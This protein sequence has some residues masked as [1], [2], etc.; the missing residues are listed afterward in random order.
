MSTGPDHYRKSERFLDY[1][2]QAYNAGDNASAA[3]AAAIASGHAR[4]ALTG[5]TVDAAYGDLSSPT[6][7][8]WDAVLGEGSDR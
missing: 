4:L 3:I 1:A 2:E 8:A 5:A 7:E 6:D